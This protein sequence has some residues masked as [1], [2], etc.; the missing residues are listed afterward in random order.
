MRATRSQG[1]VFHPWW[2]AHGWAE[3]NP[4]HL[5][6]KETPHPTTSPSTITLLG[7]P[8][9]A[10][11]GFPLSPA[12]PGCPALLKTMGWEDDPGGTSEKLQPRWQRDLQGRF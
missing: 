3:N 11:G 1:P 10:E 4:L 2:S 12:S 5:I 6:V 7:P 8:A 9:R